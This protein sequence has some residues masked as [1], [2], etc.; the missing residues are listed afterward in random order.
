MTSLQRNFAPR[1]AWHLLAGSIL[2]SWFGACLPDR[3]DSA[4][5]SAKISQADVASDQASATGCGNGIVDDNE[6]CDSKN[7]GPCSGCLQCQLRQAWHLNDGNA[8]VALPNTK[9]SSIAGVLADSK[10]GLSV[11]FWFNSAKLPIKTANAVSTDIIV[12]IGVPSE[13]SKSPYFGIGLSRE[14]DKNVMYPTCVYSYGAGLTDLVVYVQGADPILKDTWHHLRCAIS[15]KTNRVQMRVD[16]G[17]V[18]QSATSIKQTGIKSLFD[19]KTMGII[20]AVPANKEAPN[21]HFIGK[22]DELRV[23]IGSHADDFTVFKYRYD[24]TEP[25]TAVLYHMDIGAAQTDLPDA[26][27]KG[28]HAEQLSFVNGNPLFGAKHLAAGA[29]GCYGFAAEA[30]TCKVAAPWCSK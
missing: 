10:N 19:E 20:G 18:R 3:L 25:G 5:L 27:T 16:G 21:Q 4:Q 7:G 8:L 26:T 12:A 23:V 2:V 30:T 17:E 24:G 1:L 14:G 15:G 29:D 28:L 9:V 11:E 13:S 22:L 6:Q